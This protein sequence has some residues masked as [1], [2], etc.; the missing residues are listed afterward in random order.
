MIKEQG[1]KQTDAITNQN[2]SFPA[3]TNKD[4]H[5]D[6]YKE[7]F[8][9]LVKERFDHVNELMDEI[10]QNNWIYYFKGNMF[11]IRFHDYNN[12]K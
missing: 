7:I 6:S 10:N 2:K 5:E 3:L 12:G 11:R 8:D 4:D 9:E 1:R